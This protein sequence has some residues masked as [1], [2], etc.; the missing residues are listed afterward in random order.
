MKG[1]KRR[2]TER[3]PILGLEGVGWTFPTEHKTNMRKMTTRSRRKM[4]TRKKKNQE[5]DDANRK[6]TRMKKG[7]TGE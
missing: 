3:G 5:S 1:W 6:K 7:Q 4:P 2:E